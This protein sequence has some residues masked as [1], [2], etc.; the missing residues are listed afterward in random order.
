[1]L[2]WNSIIYFNVN[3]I[4]PGDP[5]GSQAPLST[6]FPRQ[7]YWSGLPF[8]SP[9]DLPN[10]EIKSR[11]PALQADSLLS[12]PPGKPNILIVDV[13]YICGCPCFFFF[14]NKLYFLE[15]FQIHS[16]IE[17]KV[18]RFPKTFPWPPALNKH[19]LPHYRHPLSEWHTCYRWRTCINT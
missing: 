15:Q 18:Q 19:K 14:L 3:V 2:F 7:E 9:G 10:P 6:G 8:P 4:P 16:K 17:Q 12:E 11:S 5:I 1:M 13:N